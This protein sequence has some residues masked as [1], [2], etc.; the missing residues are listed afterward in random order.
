MIEFDPPATK[1]SVR[2]ASPPEVHVQYTQHA[3]Q[4]R[5]P[6]IILRSWSSELFW[7]SFY[8]GAGADTVALK[9]ADD[10]ALTVQYF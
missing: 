10:L 8:F 6:V 3:E 9:G 2:Q 4:K 7:L 1:R 5:C